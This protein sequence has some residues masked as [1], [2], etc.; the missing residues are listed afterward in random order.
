MKAVS[1]INAE[2]HRKHRMPRNATV[3]MRIEW[4]LAH[5]RNCA[6][7]TDLPPVLKREMRKRGIKLPA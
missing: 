1:N 7:R 6:C 3:D 4:H 5:L 2:W